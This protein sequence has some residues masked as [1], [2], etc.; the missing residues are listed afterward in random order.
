MAAN[1]EDNLVQ[2][3]RPVDDGIDSDCSSSRPESTPLPTS[4]RKSRRN[5]KINSESSSMLKQPSRTSI[6]SGFNNESAN[7]SV[8]CQLVK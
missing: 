5:S 7:V 6:R 4:H 3:S 1:I 2:K 8:P